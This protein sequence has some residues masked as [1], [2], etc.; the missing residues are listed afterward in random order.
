MTHR[1]WLTC[2][3]PKPMLRFLLGTEA[4]RVTDIDS[5]PN[6]K[7]SNRKLRLFACSCY[8][9]LAPL[10]PEPLARSAVQLAERLADGLAA[11]DELGQAHARLQKACDALE[12]P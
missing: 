5:F 3:N 1:E 8:H 12:G 7:G 10:L 11:A 9:R 6:C 2:T 4:P